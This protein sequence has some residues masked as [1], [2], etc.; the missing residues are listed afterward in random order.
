MVVSAIS[1]LLRTEPIQW[2]VRDARTS[3]TPADTVLFLLSWEANYELV[4]LLVRNML[5]SDE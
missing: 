4:I 1:T 5:V 3:V 2:I